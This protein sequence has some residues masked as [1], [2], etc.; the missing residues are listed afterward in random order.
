MAGVWLIHT[1]IANATHIERHVIALHTHSNTVWSLTQLHCETGFDVKCQPVVFHSKINVLT[2]K[3]A[4]MF[5][6]R[7]NCFWKTASWYFFFTSGRWCIDC[8]MKGWICYYLETLT[9]MNEP[10]VQLCTQ[11]TEVTEISV[12]GIFH[13]RG[14]SDKLV[15]FFPV[16]FV[17]S[18]PFTDST[19]PYL[20]A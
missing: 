8:C 17:R 14:S 3:N 16:L 19:R 12:T 1:C 7:L 11:V 6:I 9:A 20:Q 13:I 2:W 15:C 18:P 5:L 10:I 4:D